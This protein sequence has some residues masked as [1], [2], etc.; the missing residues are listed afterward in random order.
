MQTKVE[1]VVPFRCYQY[2]DGCGVPNGMYNFEKKFTS[3]D[4][5]IAF[6]DLLM[7]KYL[8]SERDHDE[9]LEFVERYVTSGYLENVYPVIIRVTIEEEI[10]PIA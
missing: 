3:P 1:Y 8:L 4:E 7:N 9:Y 5:A 10:G 6:Y 2:N